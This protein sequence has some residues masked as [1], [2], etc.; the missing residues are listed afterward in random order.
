MFEVA[1]IPSSST[2]M[3]TSSNSVTNSSEGPWP[4]IPVAGP[5]TGNVFDD[6]GGLIAEE[7][8]LV[9]NV[10]IR[11]LN[12]IWHNAPLVAPKDVPAFVGYTTTALTL[13][14]E[15]HDGEEKVIF[16]ALAREGLANMVEGNVEQ[17]RAF[18]S[19]MESLEEYLHSVEK[20]PAAYD[21]GKVRD[22]LKQFADPLVQHLHDEIP[23]IRPEILKTVNK[24][25]LDQIGKDFEAHVKS[26]GGFT[27]LFPFAIG[28]HNPEHGVWP[29]VPGPLRWLT[30]HVFSRVNSSWWKFSPYDLS[31]RPQTYRPPSI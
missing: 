12:A 7:M 29:P 22:L 19:A 4:V 1:H 13:I 2:K 20:N 28:A 17:H 23:T 27:T 14:H 9:H 15:H 18:H 6:F 25:A 30:R 10:F 26:I 11:S 16:P 3:A 24:E 21:G 8:C 31:G 5:M